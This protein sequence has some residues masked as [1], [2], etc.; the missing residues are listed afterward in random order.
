LV[1]CWFDSLQV[2]NAGIVV[3]TAEISDP[4]SFQQEVS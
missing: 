3:A 2:N 4:E 1:V